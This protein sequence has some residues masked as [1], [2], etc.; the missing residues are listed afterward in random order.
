MKTYIRHCLHP[1][2]TQNMTVF[3]FTGWIDNT[4]FHGVKD[5]F[6]AERK[7]IRI[8]WALIIMSYIAVE[9]DWRTAM[10]TEEV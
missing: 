1:C 9:M 8:I 5:C 6:A 4:S 7:W 2:I 10:D 3:T